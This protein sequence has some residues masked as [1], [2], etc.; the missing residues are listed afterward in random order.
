MHAAIIADTFRVKWLPVTTSSTINH[1]KWLDWTSSM[2]VPYKPIFIGP[3]SLEGKIQHLVYK[4]SWSSEKIPKNPKKAI[5][6]LKKRNRSGTIQNFRAAVI[7]KIGSFTEKSLQSKTL[8]KIRERMDKKANNMTVKTLRTA[9]KS[10]GM[11]SDEDTFQH[12]LNKMK[13]HLNSI[14]SIKTN[15][16][17]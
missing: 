15:E 2:N 17:Q 6:Y 12:R 1:F 14:I 5:R 8:S 9:S 16:G 10:K 3:G 7:W 4:Y 13:E 11:L